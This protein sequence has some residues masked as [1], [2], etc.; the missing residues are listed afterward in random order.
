MPHRLLHLIERML[1]SAKRPLERVILMSKI[2]QPTDL[3]AT[4]HTTPDA[5]DVGF[6]GS[7]AREREAIETEAQSGQRGPPRVPPPV[8]VQQCWGGICEMADRLS[9]DAAVAGEVGR[10]QEVGVPMFHQAELGRVTPLGGS[11]AD[12]LHR[13]RVVK[14]R[15]GAPEHR[16]RGPQAGR[17]VGDDVLFDLQREIDQRWPVQKKRSASRSCIFRGLPHQHTLLDAGLKPSDQ[18]NKDAAISRYLPIQMLKVKMS[19]KMHIYQSLEG[20]SL[21]KDCKLLATV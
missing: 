2:P 14:R 17:Q 12:A 9:F 21:S 3:T 5:N 20:L 16:E 11:G 15:V 13:D 8:G 19:L 10:R 18:R 4:D 1:T 7:E 6:D